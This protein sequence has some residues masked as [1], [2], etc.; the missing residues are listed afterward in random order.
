MLVRG[1]ESVGAVASTSIM[2]TESGIAIDRRSMELTR[3][4][5]VNIDRR[6]DHRTVE[7]LERNVNLCSLREGRLAVAWRK[8]LLDR[9]LFEEIEL[10]DHGMDNTGGLVTDS[11]K[12]SSKGDFLFRF[13]GGKLFPDGEAV[14]IEV[15]YVKCL[16]K[17]T[18]KLWDL[19]SYIK[20][21]AVVLL[22]WG[23]GFENP[24]C[25]ALM[26]P[27]QMQFLI[28]DMENRGRITSQYYFMGYKP[29]MMVCEHEFAN[30]FTPRQRWSS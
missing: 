4:D 12:T 28:D 21:N 29:A 13:Y 16:D 22:I 25:W 8:I 11:T 23:E 27:N 19:R 30:Y 9:G 10:E 26:G 18:F 20:Q 15:K 5:K 2:P 24:K 1:A 6:R 14:V 3:R 7:E 17:A